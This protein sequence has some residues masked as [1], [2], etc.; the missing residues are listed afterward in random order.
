[1]GKS[2]GEQLIYGKGRKQLIYLNELIEGG[3]EDNREI[4]GEKI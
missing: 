2:F 4:K 3:K 1:M